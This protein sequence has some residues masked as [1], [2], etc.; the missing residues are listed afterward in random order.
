MNDRKKL[1]PKVRDLA[2]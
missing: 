2:T 1:S